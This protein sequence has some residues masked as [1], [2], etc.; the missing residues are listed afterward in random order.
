VQGSGL[1]EHR[2]NSYATG[3][4]AK[5][6]KNRRFSLPTSMELAA[7]MQA[8]ELAGRGSENVD[9]TEEEDDMAEL[10]SFGNMSNNLSIRYSDRPAAPSADLSSEFDRRRSTPSSHFTYNNNY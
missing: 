4:I 2:R 6:D 5:E 3:D 7:A 9:D 1:K 10:T 8:K